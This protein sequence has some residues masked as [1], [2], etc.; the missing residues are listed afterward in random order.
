MAAIV[1][2][3]SLPGPSAAPLTPA[4]RRSLSDLPGARN[5][6]IN[7]R[8]YLAYQRID[9]PPMTRTE[10]AMF[11]AWWHDT[12]LEGA[13]WFAAEWPLPAGMVAGVR[14]FIAEPTRQYIG[15]GGWRQSAAC[16][17]RG[18]G[19]FPTDCINETF[20]SVGLGRYSLVSG[21]AGLFTSVGTPHGGGLAIGSQSSATTAKIS[22]AIGQ[23]VISVLSVKFKLTALNADDAAFLSLELNGVAK[24]TLIPARE[25]IFDPTRKGVLGIDGEVIAIAD[26][27]L[28]VDEWY[29]IDLS[30]IQGQGEG[31]TNATLTKL[32]DS[33]IVKNIAYAFD[34]SSLLVN[35]L[36]FSADNGGVT[37]PTVYAGVRVC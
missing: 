22:R 6:R 10:M 25:A 37:S 2:P 26:A 7:Q 15:G 16:E 36:R 23:S 31:N 11:R 28:T 1:Y 29:R 21:D 4:E 32:S 20:G 35:Q 18:R 33:S 30:I 9:W 24:V 12:L 14:K 5:A 8:D 27:A 3:T 19:E 34:H 17:V 13:A